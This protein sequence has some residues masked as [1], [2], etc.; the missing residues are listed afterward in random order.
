V[1]FVAQPCTSNRNDV[2]N[3]KT[4]ALPFASFQ[5]YQYFPDLVPS[6]ETLGQADAMTCN[7]YDAR[8]FP[9]E[10]PTLSGCDEA[11]SLKCIFFSLSF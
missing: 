1:I 4:K 7:A 9:R 2:N 10:N 11:G 3:Q 6:P 5:R 8:F